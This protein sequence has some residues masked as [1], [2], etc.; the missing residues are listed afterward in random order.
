MVDTLNMVT[1]GFHEPNCGDGWCA[2]ER[3]QNGETTEIG[4]ETAEGGGGGE[5]QVEQGRGYEL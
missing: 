2:L 4:T 5:E 3:N 1:T